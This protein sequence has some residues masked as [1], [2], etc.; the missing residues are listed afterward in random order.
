MHN[1]KRP[2]EADSI[3]EIVYIVLLMLM[4]I[5]KNV[6][7]RRCIGQQARIVVEQKW[8]MLVLSILAPES[9][10]GWII[11]TLIMM[12]TYVSCYVM[13]IRQVVSA[14]GKVVTW[15]AHNV[16]IPWE[17]LQEILSIG[18][19]LASGDLIWSFPSKCT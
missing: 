3:R 17:S 6:K 12:T 14:M 4:H 13:S 1:L 11:L 8:I 10:S 15:S 9:L 18:L 19:S 7:G 2:T 5:L 16:F